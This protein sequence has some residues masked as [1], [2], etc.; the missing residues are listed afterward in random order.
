MKTNIEFLWDLLER[1]KCNFEDWE[2]DEGKESG[3]KLKFDCVKS[4]MDTDI[5]RKFSTKY[6]LASE[7]VASFCES[8]ATYVD[9]PKEKWFKYHP[10]IEVKVAAP[11]KVEEKTITYNDP[12]VPTSYV[13]KPPFPVR[14][15]DHA[16]ALTVVHKSNIKTYT[17]PKKINVE[18]GIAMIKDLLDED[19][20]GHVISFLFE[21][22]NI[23][24]PDTKTRRP[25]VGT[26]VISVKIGDHC[27]HGLSD[28]GV[29]ANAIP[30]FLYKEIMHDIAPV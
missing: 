30:Y 10:P 14:I 23:A 1:I 15:K 29:S 3:I 19:L 25:V 7:I 28:M 18:P 6:G 16:K 2:L 17:P 27:Y 5:F 21:T 20:H 9:L 22:A 11:I 8:F 26:P 13:E 4:F 24:R 12:I